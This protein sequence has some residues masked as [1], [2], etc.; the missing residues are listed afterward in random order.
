[1]LRQNQRILLKNLIFIEEVCQDYL[2]QLLSIALTQKEEP[3]DEETDPILDECFNKRKNMVPEKSLDATI[4]IPC[5]KKTILGY[6][7]M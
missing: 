4:D 5:I 2:T 3:T 7:M 6:S 1:M